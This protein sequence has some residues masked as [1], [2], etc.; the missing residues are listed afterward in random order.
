[1]SARRS[2]SRAER[3]R[4]QRGAGAALAT[5]GPPSGGTEPQVGTGAAAVSRAWPWLAAAGLVAL[6][7]AVLAWR[8]E[9]SLDLGFHL[10]SGRWIL[11]HGAWPET[12]PFTY[13]VADHPYIDMHGLFQ[14]LLAMVER[15]WG[16]AGV[17]GFRLALVLGATGFLLATART[18][19]F[20]ARIVPS[21]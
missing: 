17:G 12:D 3:R 9:V 14:V 15:A 7:A 19:S 21:G 6:L 4:R 8:Q 10:A 20:C 18:E 2:P 16:L 5:G 11:E 13:T 1:M